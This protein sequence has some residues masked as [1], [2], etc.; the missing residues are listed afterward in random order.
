MWFTVIQ[1]RANMAVKKYVW[2]F[3]L[4]LVEQVRC[5]FNKYL[6]YTILRAMNRRNSSMVKLSMEAALPVKSVARYT[7]RLKAS[8][9][10]K[11]ME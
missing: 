2:C 6:Q 9:M 10:I 7:I 5:C 4:R 11:R 1:Y 3:S 8:I